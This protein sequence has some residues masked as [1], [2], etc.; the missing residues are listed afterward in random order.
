M[1]HPGFSN[2][3]SCFP[4]PLF[5]VVNFIESHRHVVSKLLELCCKKLMS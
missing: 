4:I 2:A 5:S 1:N 3:A